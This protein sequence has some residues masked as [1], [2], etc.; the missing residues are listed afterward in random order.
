MED[1]FSPSSVLFIG[2]PGISGIQNLG[3]GD[4][5]GAN[6]ADFEVVVVNCAS[7]IDFIDIAEMPQEDFDKFRDDLAQLAV[8]TAKLVASEGTLV[9]MCPEIC[10]PQRRP[11]FN[12]LSWLPVHFDV[13]PHES[14]RW[15]I[16]MLLGLPMSPCCCQEDLKRKQASNDC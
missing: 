13:I 3:W 7:L 2:L 4:I 10:K 9:A 15:L 11:G 14:R 8:R 1:N 12:C 5:H 6:P 16:I